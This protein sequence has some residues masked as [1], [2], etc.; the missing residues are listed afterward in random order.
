MNLEDRL[1]VSTV[2]FRD[3]P[4]AGALEWLQPLGIPRIDLTAIVRYCD[5]FDPFLVDVG[6]D[7]CIRVRDLVAG[8]GMQAVS[9]TGY[10]ANPLAKDLN[11]DDWES[12]V[13]AY[14]RC[15]MHLGAQ[16]LNFPPGS[17]APAPEHW[18]GTA[19]H[20]KPWLRDGALRSVHAHLRPVIALQSNSLLRTTQQALDFLQILNIPQAGLAVDPA[21]LAAVG[22]DPAAS[23]RKMGDAVAF[24]MLRDTDGESYNLPPGKGRLDFEEILGALDE[25]NYQGPLVLAI[26]DIRVRPQKRA[27]LLKWGVDYL[28]E[29]GQR[30]AA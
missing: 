7:E 25:I 27:D 11:G 16:Y 26:D 10:P 17:P 1:A 30:K 19:E 3:A 12:G 21:H 18:R 14:V 9:V 5:H 28:A 6:E 2:T 29:R 23:L 20:A 22:E 24:V 13:D 8:A 15:A 4:L